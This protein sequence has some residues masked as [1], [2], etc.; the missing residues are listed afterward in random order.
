MNEMK[1]RWFTRFAALV[2]VTIVFSAP[3]FSQAAEQ[4]VRDL[5]KKITQLELRVAKLEEAILRLQ[6]NQAKPAAAAADGWKSKSNWRS[7]KKGMTKDDVERILGEP[8][9]V[10]PNTHY[11]DIWYYPDAQGGFASFDTNGILTSWNEI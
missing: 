11:G 4:K 5:E 1:K 6:K 10:V 9:K 7:L 8:P 3:A 2:V